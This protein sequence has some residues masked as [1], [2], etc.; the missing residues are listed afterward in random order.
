MTGKLSIATNRIL[1]GAILCAL[2]TLCASVKFIQT[3]SART[4]TAA[5]MPNTGAWATK[6]SMPTAR[7]H[8]MSGVIN[9][10]L[11]VAGG[12]A[13]S[14][15]NVVTEL[16]VLEVF[17][18]AANSWT[19]KAPMP[20]ARHGGASAAISG[21]LYV[22]GGCLQAGNQFTNVLEVYD[23]ATNAWT[24]KVPMPTSRC[25]AEA[26]AIDGKL[27]VVG[28]AITS[29]NTFPR[30]NVLEVYDP[31]TDTWTTK[32]PMPT[33][34][35]YIAAE[36]I[37][38]KLYVV[39]GALNG[40]GITGV[41]E[42]Y[43]P[44]ANTWSTKAPM[45]T[46]RYGLSSG[47]LGGRLYAVG[48]VPGNTGPS[49]TAVNESY[50]PATN[51]WRAEDS[52]PTARW[53]TAT[54]VINDTLYVVGGATGR[55]VGVPLAVNEAFSPRL[56]RVLSNSA[57]PGSNVPLPIELVSLGDENAMGFSLTFDPSVLSNPQVSLGADAV[58][59]TLNLNTS[60]TAQGKLGVAVALPASQKFTA[61]TRQLV[62][63]T[64]TIAANAQ[65][66]TTQVGFG[67]QPIAREVV[68]SDAS[69][70][71][72]AY[73]PSTVRVTPGY[74]ADVSPRPNGNN[75]GAVTI[76]DWV[77]VG[78]F[79]AG[80]DTAAM[81][82]E[83]QR[84]DCAPRATLGDGKISIADWVQAGRYAAGIDAA[85]A[86]GGPT[87]PVSSLQAEFGSEP[88]ALEQQTS[89]AVRAASSGFE[90]GQNGRLV[91][92]LDALGNENALGFSLNFD[93]S[94]LRF[95]SAALGS[96]AEDA[97]L[98]LN[99]S[100]IADGR[101]GI[102]L[103]LPAGQSF[104]AGARQLLVVTFAAQANASG[105]TAVKIG[106]EPV[107][108]EVVDA[109][110]QSLATNWSVVQAAP[111]IEFTFVPPY[112]SSQTVRGRVSGVTP[113]NAYVFLF[114]F[115]PDLGW[116]T[117][118]SCASP[119]TSINSDLTWETAYATGGIDN[120]A[121]VLAAYLMPANFSMS[122]V[123][124]AASLPAEL[125]QSALAPPAVATRDNPNQRAFQFSNLDWVVK[126]SAAPVYPGPNRF[127]DSTDNV[128][129]DAQGRLHLKM[130]KRNGEWYSAEII[131]RLTLGYGEY[132]FYLESQVDQLDPNVVL[133]L[134]TF[135]MDGN[136]ANR[137]LDV[138]FSRW[139]NP[140]SSF[141]A[142]Y[143][144][145]PFT[146]PANLHPF[147]MTACAKSVHSFDWRK[148]RIIFRSWCGDTPQPA[149]PS[150][151]IQQ[152][153]YTS[154]TL[155]QTFDER[156][157]L[158]L[159]AVNPPLNGQDTEIVVSKFEFAPAVVSSVSA[160][161]FRGEQLATESIAAAFGSGFATTTQSATT[162]PLPT[163]L[164]GTTVKVKDS[165]GA[166]RSAPL[167]FVSPAQINFLIPPGTSTGAAQITITSGNGTVTTGTSQIAPVV[168]GLFAANA[169][170]RG[171]AAA[172]VLRRN[173][174][175]QD[176]YEKVA[177]LNPQGQWVSVPIDLGPAT[178]QV[179]LLLYGTG[180]RFRSSL[181]N[182]T[183]QIGGVNAEVLFAG[184]Q[185]TYVGLDQVN[186]RLPRSL[187]GRGEVDVVLN[188]DSVL[189]NVVRVS[190][191]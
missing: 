175:G 57:A 126:A 135:G 59:A 37:G 159:W 158:N 62:T 172:D 171:V 107:A 180:V 187:A 98:N 19:T 157:H 55:G 14:G 27:Y 20:T 58:G 54:G 115:V 49:E 3:A 133:G 53:E 25:V 143:V 44:A 103:A 23:P 128:S 6:T 108:R 64:F 83:F 185:Q 121:T 33:S 182:V 94:Q 174:A 85:A 99:T 17:D 74:E 87:G 145:Q 124:G 42:V 43:D 91:L 191:K 112:G 10:L 152:W 101:V 181:N 130:T 8:P 31:A 47:F 100:Q 153:N 119:R 41:L 38:G 51:T 36:E 165:T 170:G 123:L 97:T 90:P 189:A 60:Q 34:R 13:V 32:A 24:T 105:A 73:T 151:L 129:R 149:D 72:A 7:P 65:A 120:Q 144:V 86:A 162:V 147:K 156:V 63:V 142:Q 81:G 127:S 136:F 188:V 67:D 154:P 131:S 146:N 176:G 82:S 66:T 186:V 77:Q 178:D 22:A 169:D 30:I 190:I 56:L 69:V 134:F 113:Q 183:C 118:P 80:I 79:A 12:Y 163:T 50:D 138:E 148:E 40:S 2:I 164:A 26:A 16:N 95:V 102:A 114:I 45:P 168:P 28:G 4:A 89:R 104:A 177:Q 132:R 155:P 68:A 139:G 111:S 125:T 179:F 137:E 110:A 9:G 46:P 15:A 141:N 21:K 184:P 52:M 18:P 61:G 109:M 48:G 160:A 39:G 70:L 173:V 140:N 11:Y 35:A 92:E 96:G 117:K 75:N 167:F 29:N 161:S 93:P 76:A 106:D 1:V 116:Y 5:L 88:L 84:A 150:A 71:P 166:E 122:C 78:I